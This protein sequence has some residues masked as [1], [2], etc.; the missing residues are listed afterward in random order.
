MRPEQ[1]QE[2]VLCSLRVGRW[3]A[4]IRMDK[5]KLGQKVPKK[6][7]RAMQDLIDDRTLLADMATIRRMA[8][9]LLQRNSIAFPIDSVY[10]IPKDKIVMLDEEFTKLKTE[11]DKRFQKF[12]KQYGKLKRDFK[13]K[14]PDYYD[15]K[16][17]PSKAALKDKFYFRWQFFHF[18]IPTKE[19]KLLSPKMYKREMEKLA[20]MVKQMEEMTINLIGNKLLERVQKLSAQCESGKINAGTYNSVDRFLKRWDDLWKDH[21][22]EK[23]LTMIMSRLKREMKKSS[24]ERLKN[25]E[26]FR[27]KLNTQ[28]ES[29]MAKIKKIPNFELKRKL[30]I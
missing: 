26:D 4:S 10:W 14:Y 9:G 15:E 22:D 17:Y 13:K 30:D 19:T 11:N 21:V 16:K 1:L 25:N 23:K 20:G 7:V 3:D 6:I 5:N 2:G 28:L 8:K 12:I 29:T 24:A 18:Q 27:S